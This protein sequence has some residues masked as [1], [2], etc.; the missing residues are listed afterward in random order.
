MPSGRI[1]PMSKSMLK[2]YPGPAEEVALRG[3][4]LAHEINTLGTPDRPFVYGSFLSSLDGRIALDDGDK[5]GSHVPSQITSGNDFRLLLELIAQADCLVTHGHYMRAIAEGRLDDIL[6][7]GTQPGHADLVAWREQQGMSLQP[8]VVIA[9]G[10]L[11]FPIPSSLLSHAQQIYIATGRE[12]EQSRVE[13]FERQGYRVII[14][15]NGKQ[16]EGAALASALGEFGFRSLYL[17]AGPKMLETMLRQQALSRLYV[18]I[19]HRLVGGEK[20]HTMISGPQLDEYGRLRL[21][22]LYYDASAPHGAGQ[23]FAQF[24]PH[25]Q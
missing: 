19:A 14:A 9:S 10:S 12:A 13:Q 25:P 3:S 21:R 20:F 17:L 23:W 4:Y 8:A 22:A 7:V 6:Q 24:E 16:V 18:T 5:G 15:G 1:M 2:L 11:D